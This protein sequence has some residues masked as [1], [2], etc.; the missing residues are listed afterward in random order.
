[1]V[2]GAVKAPVE[3]IDPAE[4]DQDTEVCPEAVK[5]CEPP[6]ATE[7][8]E[9]ETAMGPPVTAGGL[10]VMVEV[11]DFVPSAELVAVTVTVVLL[12]IVAGAV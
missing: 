11:A 9:G 5:V 7:T 2:D 8:V 1:M 12:A 6:S 4:A 10:R 3:V